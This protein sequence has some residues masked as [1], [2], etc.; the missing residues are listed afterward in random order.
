MSPWSRDTLRAELGP[1]RVALVRRHARWSRRPEARWESAL[2]AGDDPQQWAG[3]L[4]ALDA[5]LAALAH[6]RQ[7][8][9]H[10]TLSNQFVRYAVLPWS[11][12]LRSETE[13]LAFARHRMRETYG[14]PAETWEIVLATGWPGVPRVA[15]AVERGLIEALVELARRAQ[16]RLRAVAPHFGL[17]ADSRRRE[18]RGPAFWLAVVESGRIVLARSAHG[19][20]LSL[21]AA[22]D[23]GAPA[24]T[25]LALLARECFGLDEAEAP[26]RIYVHG[27]DVAERSALGEAGWETVPLGDAPQSAAAEAA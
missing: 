22:R 16:L 8:E 1:Q 5:G 18:L 15:A 20:W 24:A 27:L 13:V 19:E 2:A 21:A 11:D 17:L 7:A 9:L 23:A 25:L 6:T 26:K 4:A 3:A 12:D 10:V 14:E